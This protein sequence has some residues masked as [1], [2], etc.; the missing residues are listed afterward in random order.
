MTMN[1]LGV[2]DTNKLNLM[3][4]DRD[5]RGLLPSE[6]KRPRILFRGYP[7]TGKTIRLLQM[8]THY[9]SS[10]RKTLFLCYNKVLASDV[11]RMRDAL[12]ERLPAGDVEVLD[13]FKLAMDHYKE[14]PIAPDYDGWGGRAV[15]H[16]RDMASLRKFDMVLLDEAQDMKAWMFELAELLCSEDAALCVAGGKGQG[17]YGKPCDRY[18]RFVVEANK[19]EM[20][21]NFRNAP[22]IGRLA[23]TF[24]EGFQH[25][26]K[27]DEMIGRFQAK[28]ASEEDELPIFSGEGNGWPVV[29]SYDP[30]KRKDEIK[31]IVGDFVLLIGNEKP[32]DLL[33][34][35][36]RE[37][38]EDYHRVRDALGEM[39]VPYTDYVPLSNRRK[40]G[41][42]NRIR[43][44]T[45]HS[46]RGIEGTRALIFGFHEIPK[47]SKEKKSNS[48]H[49]GYI[50]LSRAMR[51]CTICIPKGESSKAT[52]FLK[53]SLTKLQEGL[54]KFKKAEIGGRR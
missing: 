15:T 31:R 35:F 37:K 52:E 8:M 21:R 16:M 42:V 11:R 1:T 4:D 18:E 53:E 39:K 20:R 22:N 2:C 9:G 33:I 34:L 47:I 5:V 12:K 40:E 36:P 48:N 7:G 49:L 17:L 14:R 54:P 38:N 28:Q 29:E 24:F 30:T 23:H 13:V 41:H 26:K 27:A 51:A 43:L 25:P 10:P 45:F 46:S 50:A 19:R 32:I 6:M 3:M 44:C